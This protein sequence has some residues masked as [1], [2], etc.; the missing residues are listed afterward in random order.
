MRR[1]TGGRGLVVVST[2]IAAF[3]A[4]TAVCVP[5]LRE[6]SARRLDPTAAAA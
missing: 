1:A 3:C 6:T 2:V 5:A 4:L